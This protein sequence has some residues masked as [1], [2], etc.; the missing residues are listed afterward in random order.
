MKQE[1]DKYYFLRASVRI[2]LGI[3]QRSAVSSPP[4][5]GVRHGASI[6]PAAE[7]SFDIRH[8]VL[9]ISSFSEHPCHP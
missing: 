2:F 1:A 3:G 5:F 8:F 6:H 9:R 7:L 4:S